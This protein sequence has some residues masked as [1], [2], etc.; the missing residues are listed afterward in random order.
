MQGCNEIGI[1]SVGAVPSSQYKGCNDIVEESRIRW[2]CAEFIMIKE[3]KESSLFQRKLSNV[4][5]KD[6]FSIVQSITALECPSK[7]DI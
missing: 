7:L 2:G 6:L 1:G 4:F 5:G 3:C